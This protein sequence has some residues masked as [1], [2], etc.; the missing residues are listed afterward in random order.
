MRVYHIQSKS[1]E[2]KYAITLLDRVWVNEWRAE[3][4]FNVIK[5]WI[6]PFQKNGTLPSFTQTRKKVENST[7]IDDYVDTFAISYL[8]FL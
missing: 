1:F 4:E 2:I 8:K 6:I 3:T 5:P 7:T